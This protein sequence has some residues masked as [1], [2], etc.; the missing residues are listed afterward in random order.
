M[1]DSG[2]ADLLFDPAA[3][4]HQTTT[5][6]I[7]PFSE[8]RKPIFSCVAIM[9]LVMFSFSVVRAAMFTQPAVAKVEKVGGLVHLRFQI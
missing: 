4:T 9:L 7:G 6:F 2:G 8:S 3:R 5:I 1:T